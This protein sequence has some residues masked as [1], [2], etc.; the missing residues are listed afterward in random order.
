ML[1]LHHSSLQL[2]KF[3]G[4]EVPTRQPIS[5]YNPFAQLS[6]TPLVHI[7]TNP[8]KESDDW[9]N[10]ESVND[11]DDGFGEFD[12]KPKAPEVDK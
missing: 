5:T 10:F 3:K 9:G 11:D 7:Q 2:P 6:A 4:I 1:K 8:R 12:Q